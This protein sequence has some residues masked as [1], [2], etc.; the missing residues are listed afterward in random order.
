MGLQ[1]NIAL[2]LP[3]LSLR[4]RDKIKVPT[5]PR[6]KQCCWNYHDADDQTIALVGDEIELAA[7]ELCQWQGLVWIAY[8]AFVALQL[9]IVCYGIAG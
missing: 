7:D 1:S 5:N 4:Q 3:A 6:P 8:F 2:I 9:K